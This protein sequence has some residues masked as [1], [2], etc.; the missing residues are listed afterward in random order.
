[1]KQESD[2]PILKYLHRLRNA[3]WYCKFEKL[4]QEEQMIEEDLIQLSLIEGIYNASHRYKIMEQLQIPALTLYSNKNWYRNTTIIKVNSA[5]KY[6]PIHVK[7]R[8]KH[9]RIEDVNMK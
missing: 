8:L 7:K 6:S 5:N 2:K 4:E 9:V 3:S 1:M